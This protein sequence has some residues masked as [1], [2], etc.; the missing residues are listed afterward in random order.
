MALYQHRAYYFIGRH[1]LLRHPK[2]NTKAPDHMIQKA[3]SKGGFTRSFFIQYMLL[4]DES[5]SP[6]FTIFHHRTYLIYSLDRFSTGRSMR[7]LPGCNE[8][9]NEDSFPHMSEMTSS[10]FTTSA[11]AICSF[12]ETCARICITCMIRGS[13]WLLLNKATTALYVIFPSASASFKLIV[14]ASVPGFCLSA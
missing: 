10:I 14:Y 8:A 9:F 6:D 5:G 3:T 2:K 12:A 13:R 4:P 7:L 11:E 1:Q